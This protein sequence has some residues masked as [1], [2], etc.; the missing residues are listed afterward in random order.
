MVDGVGVDDVVVLLV[1]RRPFRM[2]Y[3]FISLGCVIVIGMVYSRLDICLWMNFSRSKENYV[4]FCF[5]YTANYASFILI[6]CSGT[7]CVKRYNHGFICVIL[8]KDV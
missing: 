1:S 4:T 3:N 7:Y 5:T 6:C 8:M 2:R